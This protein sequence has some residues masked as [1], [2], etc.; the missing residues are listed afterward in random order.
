MLRAL[1]ADLKENMQAKFPIG[2]VPQ[3]EETKRPSS[4]QV[5]WNPNTP[6]FNKYK[7]IQDKKLKLITNDGKPY[8]IVNIRPFPPTGKHIITFIVHRHTAGGIDFGITTGKRINEQYSH[9]AVEAISYNSYLDGQGFLFVEGKQ[10]KMNE[11][12]MGIM[13]ESG[14]L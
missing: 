9:D 2:Q 14:E 13:A 8:Q 5:E 3:K 11:M 12:G 4:Y 7:I 10:K 1:S 6:F